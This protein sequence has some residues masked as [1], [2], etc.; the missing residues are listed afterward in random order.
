MSMKDYYA[1]KRVVGREGQPH[2]F[3]M[4]G[5]LMV[6][7]GRSDWNRDRSSVDMIERAAGF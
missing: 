3:N 1:G 2:V 5:G 4:G 6:P 7:R